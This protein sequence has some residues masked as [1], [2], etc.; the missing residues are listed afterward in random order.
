MTLV[1]VLLALIACTENTAPKPSTT[2]AALS[3]QI[4]LIILGDTIVTMDAMGAIL[5]NSAIAVD[6]GVI[7]AVGP[8]AQITAEYS[9]METLDGENRIVMPG[10]I[11]GHSHAAMTLFRGIADDLTLM[12]WLK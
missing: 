3:G 7:L 2:A 8:A 5:E 9:A 1:T 11:N 6:D 10:L 4:D 12:D